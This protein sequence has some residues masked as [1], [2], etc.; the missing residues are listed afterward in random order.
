MP[1]GVGPFTEGCQSYRFY[2]NHHYGTMDVTDDGSTCATCNFVT[3]WWP[4]L[5]LIDH[6]RFVASLDA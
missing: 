1:Q 4:C 5:S 3:P 6:V 2:M